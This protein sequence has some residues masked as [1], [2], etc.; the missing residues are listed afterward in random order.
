[1]IEIHNDG[2][3]VRST[4]YF[5]TEHARRGYLYVSVNAGAFRVLLPQPR[6]RW[7]EDMRT[8]SEL[9]ISRGPWPEQGRADALE[10]L[11]D[12]GSDTP[13]MVTM[14]PEQWDRLPAQGDE[15]RDDLQ[16]L[17]YTQ[18][19]V[20]RLELPVRYRHAPSLPWLKPWGGGG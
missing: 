3:R 9:V 6:I 19:A 8:A 2:P 15:G 11:F 5:Q 16:G 12:D 10:L 18:G 1:V 14:L 4:N 17:I 20:L 13:F 7:L